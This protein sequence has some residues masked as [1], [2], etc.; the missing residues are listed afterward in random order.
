MPCVVLAVLEGDKFFDFLINF[1]DGFGAVEEVRRR[2]KERSHGRVAKV[3]LGEPVLDVI[4][5]GVVVPDRQ[6]R[7]HLLAL[8]VLVDGCELLVVHSPRERVD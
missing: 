7:G 5:V 2:R 8:L 6:P 3:V 1:V 4:L